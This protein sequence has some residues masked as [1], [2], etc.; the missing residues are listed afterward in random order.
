MKLNKFLKRKYWYW[1][2]VII[3][4]IIFFYPK[5]CGHWAT[6]APNMGYTYDDCTCVGIKMGAHPGVAGGD[7]VNCWGIVVSRSCYE[8]RRTEEQGYFRYYK[9]CEEEN[10]ANEGEK[11]NRNPGLGPTDRQCCQG[12]IE[13][14]VSRSYSICKK[15]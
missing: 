14:R 13:D 9:P 4:L 2:A 7:T 12:L 5:Y 15:S 1:I 11:V 3:A 6:T 10:C 8:N